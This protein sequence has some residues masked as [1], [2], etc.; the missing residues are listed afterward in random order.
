MDAVSRAAQERPRAPQIGHFGHRF[1]DDFL[2]RFL[3]D[4]WLDF[5]VILGGFWGSKS[6]ILG[7]D[8]GMIF[9]EARVHA[10]M[11]DFV[12]VCVARVHA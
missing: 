9:G 8:F 6:V 10:C 4:V 11:R 7:I 3:V 1:L 5:G 2:H 12:C